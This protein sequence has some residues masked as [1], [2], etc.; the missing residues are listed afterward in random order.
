MNNIANQL[1]QSLFKKNTLQECSRWELEI[2]ADKYPYFGIAQFLLAGK[3]KQE[4]A[5]AYKKQVQKTSLYFTNPL[6][7][8]YTLNNEPA[9]LQPSMEVPATKVHSLTEEELKFA[10][11]VED[12]P[13]QEE[14]VFQEV[15]TT[16]E[17][18]AVEEP[19]T[20]T[21]SE[22]IPEAVTEPITEA[23]VAA[24]NITTV[25]EEYTEPVQQEGTL[26]TEAIKE[27]EPALPEMKIAPLKMEPLPDPG[28]P[29]VFEAFHTVDYFAS[30]GIKLKM[31][32]LPKDK[33]GQQL[34]S[35][36]EWLKV[37]KKTTP[38]EIAKQ[39]DKKTEEKVIT[40][41]EH[42]LENRD[43]VTEAMAEVWI[44]QGNRQK[45]IELYNKLSLQNPAKSSYFA[46]LIEQLKQ[47]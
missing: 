45:A 35:F 31:D 46:A 24:E 41:A 9:S 25:Q 22:A 47:Q 8:D 14:A 40:L 5:E 10:P 30:Q 23:T 43:V 29:L 38:T 16:I 42:S 17:T 15:S 33:F 19:A 12:L 6:W 28:A 26:S 7:L 27:D 18:P 34:K 2:L 13:V 37:L 21:Q 36:T 20:L 44:K 39:V 32:E 3:L 1:A 11:K 4:G